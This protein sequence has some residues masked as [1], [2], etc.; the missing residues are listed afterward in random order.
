MQLSRNVFLFLLLLFFSLGIFFLDRFGFLSFFRGGLEN[1]FIS[2]SSYF[3]SRPKNLTEQNNCLTLETENASLKNENLSLRKLLGAPL[4][5]SWHFLPSRIIG[6]E[7]N[8]YIIDQGRSNGVLSGQAVMGDNYFAGKVIFVGENISRFV[9]FQNP[10]FKVSALVKK[11]AGG[12]I[13]GRGLLLNEGGR[14]VLTQVLISEEI[15]EGDWVFTSLEKYIPADIPIGKIAKTK[16]ISSVF[17]KSEVLPFLEL[18]NLN[19][20]FLISYK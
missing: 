13:L 4:P 8:A 11:E 19:R 12:E 7:E 10:D 15:K 14:L 1:L 6:Q 2:F 17:Q 20:V 5:S 16:K 18:Q 3:V 9:S